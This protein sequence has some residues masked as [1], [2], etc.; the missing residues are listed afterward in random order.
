MS[1]DPHIVDVV[2]RKKGEGLR[3]AEIAMSVGMSEDALK[4]LCHKHAIRRPGACSFSM[5][6]KLKDACK[7]EARRRDMQFE[8]FMRLLMSKIVQG[9]LFS[10]IIDDGK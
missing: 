4:G 3:D 9:Q 1:Y 2:R 6:Q 5:S 7:T 10:A 8:P